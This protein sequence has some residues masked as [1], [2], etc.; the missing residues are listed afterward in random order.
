MQF[1]HSQTMPY[2]HMLTSGAL[3][4]KSGLAIPDTLAAP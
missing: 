3:H 1:V 4:V 2:L